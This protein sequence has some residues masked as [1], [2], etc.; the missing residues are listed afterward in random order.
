MNM[1]NRKNTLLIAVMALMLVWLPVHVGADSTVTGHQCHCG[2][3]TRQEKEVKEYHNIPCPKHGGSCGRYYEVIRKIYHYCS[4]PY[5]DD[6]WYTDVGGD[7][8]YVHIEGR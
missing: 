7:P 4:N 6:V 2:N 8:E 3:G 5:C 1:K